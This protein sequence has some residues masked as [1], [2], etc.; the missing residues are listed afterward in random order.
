[1]RVALAATSTSAGSLP[2]KKAQTGV[3]ATH[4]TADTAASVTTWYLSVQESVSLRRAHALAPALKAAMG[5]RPYEKHWA[6]I[7]VM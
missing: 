7:M 4:S 6:T 3:A 5:C 2:A 1:M